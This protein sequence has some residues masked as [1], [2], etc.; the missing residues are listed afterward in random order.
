MLKESLCN[1][2]GFMVIESGS[3]NEGIQRVP[4]QTA[5][6]GKCLV[7]GRRIFTPGHDNNTPA[8]SRECCPHVVPDRNRC[9]RRF[10]HR[11]KYPRKPAIFQELPLIALWI[12]RLFVTWPAP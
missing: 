12:G 3:S 8:R 5:K 7:G 6:L 4:V 11:G 9:F 10:L 2:F 1:I